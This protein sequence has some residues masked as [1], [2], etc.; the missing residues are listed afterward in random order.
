MATLLV[1]LGAGIL[2]GR[3]TAPDPRPILYGIP[4]GTAASAQSSATAAQAPV[5]VA[6]AG[7]PALGPADAKVTIVEFVDY[8]CPFCGRYARETFP[9]VEKAYGNRIRYVSRHFPLSIHPHAMG[10]AI[11][12][13]CAHRLGR[14]WEYHALVFAHQDQLDARGLARQ[15]KV[16]GIDPSAFRS[17]THSSA[18]RVAVNRDLADG[19]RSGVTGTPAFFINGTVLRGAQPYAQFKAAIDSALKKA[20]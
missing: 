4:P 17:C 5:K 9:L 8:Q 19:R 12:A 18:A 15:A 16:A 14:F 6:T 20:G 3:S 10:A 2:I 1:G 11:A 7:R 13:E